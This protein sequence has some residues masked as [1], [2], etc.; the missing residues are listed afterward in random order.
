[1]RKLTKA[2]AK[3]QREG[4]TPDVAAQAVADAVNDFVGA[5]L[6]VVGG[7]S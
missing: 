6:A 4:I 3:A 5:V 7:A 1:V 2:G